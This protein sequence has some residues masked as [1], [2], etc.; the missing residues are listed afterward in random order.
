MRKALM[1][2]TVAAVASLSSGC[3]SSVP[4]GRIRIKNDS[5]DREFNVVEVSG[6]GF[7]QALSPGQSMLAPPGTTTI[8][9]ARAYDNYTR[10]Y[11]VECNRQIT[12]GITVKLIDVHLNRIAGG[13]VTT[14]SNR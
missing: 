7:S 13:C 1:T 12:R 5:Q 11:R 6:D 8:E 4:E 14:W 2:I 10:R 3:E 9:F